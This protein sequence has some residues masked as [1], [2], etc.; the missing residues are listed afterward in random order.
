MGLKKKRQEVIYFDSDSNFNF[1]YKEWQNALVEMHGDAMNALERIC[2][3]KR[4]IL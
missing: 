3:Q 1:S 2:A 4:V